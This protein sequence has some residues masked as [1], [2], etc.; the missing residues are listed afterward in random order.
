[1]SPINASP[2]APLSRSIRRRA[3][4]IAGPALTL[5]LVAGACSSDDDGFDT[6]A[7]DAYAAVGASFFGDPSA[8]PDVLAELEAAVPESSADDA[9][10]YA[11]GLEAGFNGDEEAM[12]DPEFVSAAAALGD[13]ALD[14]CD[15]ADTIDVTGVD[16]GFEGL[17]EEVA[18]GRIAVRF[19]NGT[20]AD[21]AHEMF[22]ARKADGV[23][24]TLD[25]LLEMDEDQLFSK[26]TPTAV[27]F[28]DEAGGEA[29]ALVDLEAGEYVAFCMIP[30][31]DDG[32][33]HAM[34]GMAAAFSVA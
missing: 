15:T 8:V 32:A 29:T 3:G 5:A 25:E 22:V 9:A 1:M 13:A 16:Y 28:A 24:E 26:L 27:V 33:P 2:D 6:A 14:T 12:S 31:L 23:T 7:C 21:E 18:A 30:T 4:W 11:A 34:H 19:T 17:P 20:E 10:T